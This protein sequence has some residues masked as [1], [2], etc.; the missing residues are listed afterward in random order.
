L[1]DK[2]PDIILQQII[3]LDHS[4]PKIFSRGFLQQSGGKIWRKEATVFVSAQRGASS[5]SCSS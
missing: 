5:S 3:S 4:S 2:L 1:I